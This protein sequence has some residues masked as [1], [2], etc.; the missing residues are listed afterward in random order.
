MSIGLKLN[1]TKPATIALSISS[2]IALA[3]TAST[4]IL[5]L[6][7]NDLSCS[8]YQNNTSSIKEGNFSIK[9]KL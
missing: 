4:G 7:S 3:L 6:S 2:F 5:R 8:K 9:T 1:S